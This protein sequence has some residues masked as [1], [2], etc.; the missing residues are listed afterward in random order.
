MSYL[1]PHGFMHFLYHFISI[2]YA[3]MCMSQPMP[4]DGDLGCFKTFC[5]VNVN[6]SI[7]KIDRV[8]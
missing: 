1:I 2:P 5:L 3:R 6:I 4:P 7:M 8:E